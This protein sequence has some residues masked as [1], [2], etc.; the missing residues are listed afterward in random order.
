MTSEYLM[1]SYSCLFQV[2]KVTDPAGLYQTVVDYM[3]QHK[4]DG[5]NDK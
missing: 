1:N 4:K 5:K 2:P 3:E